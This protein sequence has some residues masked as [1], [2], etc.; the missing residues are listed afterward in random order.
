MTFSLITS[1]SV[2]GKQYCVN[3]RI[4]HGQYGTVYKGHP[5]DNPSFPVAVKKPLL[6]HRD[7]RTT[8]DQRKRAL[9]FETFM[10]RQ[11]D[12]DNVARYVDHGSNDDDLYL[13]QEY[14]PETLT[15]RIRSNTVT[16]MVVVDFLLQI[17][18]ILALLQ[19]RNMIHGDLK[20]PN[21]GY[22]SQRLLKVL[23]F[24]EALPLPHSVQRP[25]LVPPE[26]L[27][28]FY[29]PEFRT[30]LVITLSFDTYTAG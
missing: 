23:D 16:Q 22:T 8:L 19:E 2:T 13:V 5:K 11:V 21:L 20:C 14:V 3:E 30:G 4:H 29:P 10:L 7:A 1:P 28:H 9:R 6:Y 15:D 12:D 17:P 25:C 18:E 26:G 27:P 24:G